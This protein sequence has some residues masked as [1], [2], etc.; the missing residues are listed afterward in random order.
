VDDSQGVTR[1]HEHGYVRLVEAWGSDEQIVAAARMSTDGAFRGWGTDT[2][3]GDERLLARLWRDRHTSP[4]E[5]AGMSLEVRAPLFVVREW[6]R[7]RTQSFNEQSARYGALPYDDY[8]PSIER[9]LLGG[10]S[11]GNRQGSGT[12][13]PH[14]A[15]EAWRTEL[16]GLQERAEAVYRLGIESG[17][18]RELSRCALTVSRYSRMRASA[19]LRNWLAF[20]ALRLAPDAQEEIR[21]YARAVATLLAERFPRTWALAKEG[22]TT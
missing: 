21:D 4:F 3:P 19:N 18:S 15:A 22:M 8:L 11:K 20:L 13:V 10:Q 16:A 6:Q 1:V 2:E 12:A 17:I 5:Q 7:H 9:V 14:A